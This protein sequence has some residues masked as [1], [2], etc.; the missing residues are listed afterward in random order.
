MVVYLVRNLV[1]SSALMRETRR[2]IQVHI[3][4]RIFPSL[5]SISDTF[6]LHSAWISHRNI[7]Q[8]MQSTYSVRQSTRQCQVLVTQVKM[9]CCFKLLSFSLRALRKFSPRAELNKFC[10]EIGAVWFYCRVVMDTVCISVLCCWESLRRTKL[11]SLY[12]TMVKKC[13]AEQKNSL[14]KF[15]KALWVLSGYYK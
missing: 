6:H 3:L 7:I 8:D 11:I 15:Q 2:F 10:N 5:I 9:F 12:T 13:S 1:L 14:E 4:V